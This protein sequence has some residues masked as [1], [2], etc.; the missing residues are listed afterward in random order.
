[1]MMAVT[2]NGL[3]LA[4]TDVDA[5]T[6]SSIDAQQMGRDLRRREAPEAS[7]RWLVDA[8]AVAKSG[9]A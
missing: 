9:E 3:S 2:V 7:L 1:V 5:P 6:A 4:V 8:A